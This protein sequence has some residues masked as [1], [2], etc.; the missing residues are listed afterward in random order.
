MA[1]VASP[2]ESA[3]GLTARRASGDVQAPVDGRAARDARASVDADVARTLGVG[4]GGAVKRWVGRIIGL[5]VV[6]AI[7][8]GM[9]VLVRKGTMS[10]VV[11][12]ETAAVAR[13]DISVVVTA[14]GTVQALN[15]VQVGTEV[16]GRVAAVHVDFNNPV[17]VG[18]VLV[19]IDPE[20]LESRVREARAQGAVARA[21]MQQASAAL[22]DARTT[23]ARIEQLRSRQIVSQADLDTA[24]AAVARADAGVASARAQSQVAAAGLSN[25]TTQLGKS[26]IRSPINGV[27]LA[28]NVEPGQTVNGQFQT[29]QLLTLAEDLT[30][31]EL[32]VDIDEADIGRV[33]EGQTATFTVAAYPGRHFASRVVELR[34]APHTVQNVVSYEAVLSFDNGE[35]L[36]RPGMTA[37]VS[38][39]SDR[40]AN[41]LTVP[42]AAL[43]FVPPGRDA[44]EQRKRL[45]QT[46]HV[47]VERTPGN[48]EPIPLQTGV[49]DGR[50]T[51]VLSGALRPGL[52]LV[53]DQRAESEP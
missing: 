15:T 2:T 32:R 11:R 3:A 38:V 24:R 41:V 7:I 8:F 18:Q 12:Y 20:Q 10:P 34:N 26:V 28:R 22:A 30:H 37:T 9:V 40:R 47:W 49:T 39:V 51:E 13:G 33:R 1:L 4:A 42:N 21:A 25:A 43:R 46:R 14:T 48:L 19:E 50:V 45:G 36:M 17:V 6:G 23:L 52:E 35:R 16:S 27:V 31:M 44:E 29:A 5:L 53:T